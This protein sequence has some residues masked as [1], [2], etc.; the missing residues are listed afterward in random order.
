MDPTK[1][2]VSA[3]VE[4]VV[5]PQHGDTD[6][7]GGVELISNNNVVLLPIP[8]KDPRDP[9]NL[10][11]WRRIVIML[12]TSIWKYPVILFFP[13]MFAAV[14]TLSLT[15][16][17]GVGAVIGFFSPQYVAEGRS[18]AEI[19]YLFTIPALA[20]G[21]ANFFSMPLA[22]AI[23]RRPVFLF[24]AALVSLMSLLC[25]LNQGYTWHLVARIF[26][27]LA[28]G[29]SEALTP[30]MIQETHFLHERG[31]ILTWQWAIQ[32][33]LSGLL[34]TISSY[35]TAVLGLRWWYGFYAITSFVVFLV[36]IVAVPETK[37]NRPLAAYKGDIA[38]IENM[39]KAGDSELAA[40]P[41]T[42]ADV[43]RVTTQ[44]GPIIDTV[45]YRGRTFWSDI[46]LMTGKPE[47]RRL[48]VCYKHMLQLL[49]FP[50]VLWVV[51]MNGVLLGINV[52]IGT[53]YG[54][55]LLD[56][57]HWL[58]SSVGFAQ[59]GQIV[60]AFVCLPVLGFYSDWNVKWMSR[61]NGGIHEP[62]FRLVPLILPMITGII[63]CVVFGQGGSYPERFHWFSIVFGYCA[64]YFSFVGA[65]IAGQAYL[66][67]AYPSAQGAVL[68]LVC[69]MRGVIQFGLS[70]GI[71]EFQ[72]AAGYAVVFGTY[73]GLTAL[74]GLLG[75][76][77][78]FTGKRIR[79]FTA[80]WKLDD[81][82][83]DP[84]HLGEG[85]RTAGLG[86]DHIHFP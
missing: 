80:R 64:Q 78:F 10:P 35:Q 75:I 19:T 22:L 50:N 6:A 8:S 33:T 4:S 74:F 2:P 12:T 27:G 9:L 49:C 29:Q 43:T 28:A 45:N 56:E 62:E 32:S 25:A 73:G 36:G 55:I 83:E 72:A 63:A 67:D 70:Y 38:T 24:S 51:L 14:G 66:L 86:G 60:I 42:E 18:T 21:I 20:M 84:E 40:N 69:A 39:V 26:L 3:H 48:V 61:R 44:S 23:G 59:G 46:K 81:D 41:K 13:K 15:V 30:M 31:K 76:V 77:I 71:S 68:V 7:I 58:S 82:K 53:T 5:L 52:S 34:S 17:S 57:Y 79:Q 47:W 54:N 1:D 37:Y 85:Y 11:A 16:V 65:S